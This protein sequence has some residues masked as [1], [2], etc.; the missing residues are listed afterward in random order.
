M[1]QPLPLSRDE[2][3]WIAV[4][5]AGLA[6]RPFRRRAT[7]ADLLHTIRHL[8]MVQ[9]DT[10]S[11]ISRSHETVLWSRLGAFD[12]AAFQ[13]LYEPQLALTEYLAHAAAIIPVETLGLFR[14]YMERHRHREDW[15][16]EPANRATM[17]RVLARIEREGPAGSRHF[18]RPGDGRR[19]EQWE[20]YGL[21]PERRALDAL[22]IRGELVLRQR[23]PGFGRVFDLPDRVI[24]GFWE[25]PA[26]GEPERERVMVLK[27]LD[28]LG[29]GTA[30]WVTDYF[31]TGGPSHVSIARSR[32]VLACLEMEGLVN[33]VVI[34]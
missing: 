24:P 27:A 28:V 22:W 16:S 29:L 31:R 30:G 11:V 2:A 19:A 8:G 9:L 32:A 33:R 21:K 25:S 1:S 7:S 10:I 17:D 34:P 26:L 12:P 15:A 14:T 4:S 6:R 5:S 20:W 13:H 3:R 18:E 23:E